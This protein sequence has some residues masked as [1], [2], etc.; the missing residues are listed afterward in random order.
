VPLHS[1]L[2]PTVTLPIP[3]VIVV[4]DEYPILTLLAPEV[5][6]PPE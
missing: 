1:A 2:Y 4:P 6:A 3:V 5:I